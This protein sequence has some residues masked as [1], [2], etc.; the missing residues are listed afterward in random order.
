MTNV[1][2]R[3]L[4]AAATAGAASAAVAALDPATGSALPENSGLTTEFPPHLDELRR[5]IFDQFQRPDFHLHLRRII[6]DKNS[7]LTRSYT[8]RVVRS[9]VRDDGGGEHYSLRPVKGSVMM[10]CAKQGHDLLD[11]LEQAYVMGDRAALERLSIEI[12]EDV[13]RRSVVAAR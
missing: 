12:D 13:N 8:P 9:N 1:S 2:R 11:R 3:K 6:Q 7:R 5:Q 4:L 10:F